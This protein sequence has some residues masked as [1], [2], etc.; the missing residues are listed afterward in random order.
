M[1]ADAFRYPTNFD[2]F[3]ARVPE[4]SSYL[5]PAA[6]QER[7]VTGNTLHALAQTDSGS[8][9]LKFSADH[10]QL[11]TFTP[12]GVPLREVR[13]QRDATGLQLRRIV[14]AYYPEG[15][16]GRRV[17]YIEV[18]T[19][20]QAFG[21]DGIAEVTLATPAGD[22]FHERPWQPS[23]GHLAA[24]EFGAWKPLVAAG[25]VA[26]PRLG[27]DAL[28]SAFT[29]AQQPT[30]S[31]TTQHSATVA[32]ATDRWRVHASAETIVRTAE[33]LA[34]G[35]EHDSGHTNLFAL[36][37]DDSWVLP[38]V[39]VTEVAYTPEELR[40]ASNLL[41]QLRAAL[42]YRAG[43]GSFL[44]LE[45]ESVNAYAAALRA[46]GVT[47]AMFWQL[48]STHAAV[49]ASEAPHSPSS[50]TSAGLNRVSL[51]SATLTPATPSISLALHVVPGEWITEQKA[52]T[53]LNLRW[54]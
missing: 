37:R 13:W 17:P 23:T 19:V 3:Q 31:T 9:H 48:T 33:R 8:V 29:R 16:P 52:P 54:P 18:V 36:R 47:R 12:S 6:A 38:L 15:D 45:G 42:E 44:E 22:E 27:A 35:D 26:E 28:N 24:P 43:R 40:R 21:A 5:E 14:D 46:T 11:T 32:T 10:C 30:P 4:G 25:Q 34:S 50:Q 20:S 51:T 53:N 2:I 1:H 49:I 7:Y 39:R 41:N